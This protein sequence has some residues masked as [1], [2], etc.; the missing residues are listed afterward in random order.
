MAGQLSRN[1]PVGIGTA[2]IIIALGVTGSAL[3]F[4]DDAPQN[5]G[6]SPV[7]ATTGMPVATSPMELRGR[8]LGMSMTSPR[9][10]KAAKEFQIPPN[11]EGVL[12]AEIAERT[13][14]RARQAGVLPGDVIQKVDKTVVTDLDG[15]YNISRK[16]NSNNTILVDVLRWGQPMTLALPAV[17]MPQ[18]APMVGGM[19]PQM[20]QPMQPQMQQPMQPQMQQPQQPVGAPGAIR[21]VAWPATP[22]NNTPW[23]CPR[24]NTT[25]AQVAAQPAGFRCPRCGGPLVPGNGLQR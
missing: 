6:F 7:G 1:I 5:A 16:L 8:W 23:V 2:L 11:V 9:S 18:Q 14:W 25:M 15:L 22:M 4:A 24:D 21:P 17:T 13:G 10:V 20:Q 12:V 19:A 3:I